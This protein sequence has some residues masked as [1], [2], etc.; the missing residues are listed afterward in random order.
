[1]MSDKRLLQ[2]MTWLIA[3]NM[4]IEI[5]KMRFKRVGKEMMHHHMFEQ[6]KS[7]TILPT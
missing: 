7:E 4:I 5:N 3:V 1:M 2:V 6:L